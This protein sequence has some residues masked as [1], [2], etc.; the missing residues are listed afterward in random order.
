MASS[1]MSVFGSP[2]SP[3]PRAS[4]A[5]VVTPD[6]APA[7][8]NTAAPDPE[9]PTPAPVTR[10]T[11]KLGKTLVFRGDLSV[12]EDVVLL[13]SVEGTFECGDSLTVGV[14]GTVVGDVL[15][16][17]VTVKGTVR[18]NI[19]GTESVVIVPGA[20]VVGDVAAPRVTVVEGARLNGTVKMIAV[21][22]A[23][24]RAEAPVVDP[25]E[26]ELSHEAVE[27][28]LGLMSSRRKA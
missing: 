26:L 14:G 16:R 6:K 27:K 2:R 28:L 4:S 21:E 15:G 23:A 11:T 3:Q 8:E 1:L 20:V 10:V 24:A 25:S 5:P 18:G 7:G 22:S 19:R 13:G 12:E 9:D 17:V